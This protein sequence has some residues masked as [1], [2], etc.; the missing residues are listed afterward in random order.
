MRVL[1]C[2]IAIGQ[3]ILVGALSAAAAQPVSSAP[4]IQATAGS[5]AITNRGTYI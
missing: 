2:S 3:H 4:E 1:I 5:D